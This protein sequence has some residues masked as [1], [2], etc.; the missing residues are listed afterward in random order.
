[1][2]DDQTVRFRTALLSLIAVASV[3]TTSFV[4][5]AASNDSYFTQPATA[6]KPAERVSPPQNLR[7]TR[8][9]VFMAFHGMN[10]VANNP[11]LDSQWSYVGQNLDGLWGN[12]GNI[13]APEIGRLTQN[14]RTRQ[15]ITEVAMPLPGQPFSVPTYRSIEQ[16]NPGLEFEREAIAFYTNQPYQ[17]DGRSIASARQALDSTNFEGSQPYTSIYTG[18]QPQNFDPGSNIAI[19]G[20]TDA[21]RAVNDGDGMFIECPNDVCNGFAYE[22]W[23]FTG[24]RRAR[25]LDRPFIWFASR[26]PN[27]SRTGW[28][29]EF[30]TMYNR[31]GQEGLWRP[32]DIVVVIAYNGM[33]PIVPESFNGQPADTTMG[34]MYWALQQ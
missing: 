5:S 2:A 10:A 18:W 3:G 16:A 12:I 1:M 7:P 22:D 28:L 34:L 17:W 26:P 25:Q 27:S 14:I 29:G 23:F 24:V 19:R 20:G 21:D 9:R 8:P 30:Q 4:V 32:G 31:V 15:L 6:I 13:S 33:Y 11:A